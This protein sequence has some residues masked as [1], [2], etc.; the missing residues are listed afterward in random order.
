MA[1]FDFDKKIVGR[2]HCD[3][4]KDHDAMALLMVEGFR[5]RVISP[6]GDH[7]ICL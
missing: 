3:H 6:M 4:V 1:C 7:L 5:D 2:K